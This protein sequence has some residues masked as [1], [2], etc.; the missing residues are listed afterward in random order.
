MKPDAPKFR[1]PFTVDWVRNQADIEIH[2]L[3]LFDVPRQERLTVV[4]DVASD[5]VA[6]EAVSQDEDSPSK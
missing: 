2:Q 5:T 3:M 1:C 6:L 4:L